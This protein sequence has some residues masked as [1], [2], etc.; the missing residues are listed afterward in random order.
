MY[1]RNIPSV[2]LE[3]SLSIRPMN[4]KYVHVISQPDANIRSHQEYFF[5]QNKYTHTQ[6]QQQQ[7]Q[8]RNHPYEVYNTQETFNP[9]NS[10]SPWSGFASKIDDESILRDQTHRIGSC[11]HQYS[12]NVNSDLYKLSVSQTDNS[13]GI[14]EFP[15]LFKQN[16]FCSFNPAANIQNMDKTTTFNNDTRI[17]RV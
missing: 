17:Q 16:Q 2:D 4:T 10:K 14:I 9:G 6:Q 11:T 8:N 3:P 15:Y 1:L 7:N 5:N 13:G 12:P